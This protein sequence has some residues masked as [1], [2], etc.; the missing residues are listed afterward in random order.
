[1]A[2]VVA[3][4]NFK[5][6]VGKTT[7][8]T[9]LWAHAVYEGYSVVIVDADPQGDATKFGMG[10]TAMRHV[11]QGGGV[12]ALASPTGQ[13]A[14]VPFHG[15]TPADLPGGVVHESTTVPRGVM[16]P[17]T[18]F[19]S[20]QNADGLVLDALPFD[21]VIVDTPPTI[22]VALFR[23]I[24]GQATTVIAPVELESY[25]CQNVPN[26]LAEINATGRGDLLA[27]GGLRFVV[28][29]RAACATHKVW[30]SVLRNTY[31]DMLLPTVIPRA[32][33]WADLANPGSTYKPKSALGK[34]VASVWGDLAND[35][36]RRK[37][38]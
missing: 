4:L 14:R 26:L 3:V 18:P 8:A 35:N 38:A 34:V 30:E 9:T 25:A 27:N 28:N 6:G 36:Q 7:I 10:A 20:V 12:E 31:G 13:L 19:W 29:K 5:G 15:N 33:A 2:N 24:A 1:M 32:T 21:V 17:A 22:P 23:S 11:P 16:I 37:T